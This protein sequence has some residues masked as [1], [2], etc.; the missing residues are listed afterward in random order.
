MGTDSLIVHVKAEDL[1]EDIAKDF[2]KRFGASNY[3]LERILPKEK[4]QKSY[5][6]NERWIRGKIIKKSVGLKA[7]TYTYFT[8]DN[9][10]SK[11]EKGTKNV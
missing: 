11:K 10:E 4:T 5:W 8:D 3:K 7:K 1:Y 9:N 2:K 6:F